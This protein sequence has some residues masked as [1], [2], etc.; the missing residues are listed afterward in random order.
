MLLSPPS[1]TLSTSDLAQFEKTSIILHGELVQVLDSAHVSRIMHTKYAHQIFEVLDKE[2]AAVT[3]QRRVGLITKFLNSSMVEGNSLREYLVQIERLL[4][5]IAGSGDRLDDELTAIV[6]LNSLPSSYEVFKSTVLVVIGSSKIQYSR[7]K[8][9]ALAEA[10]RRDQPSSSVSG[11]QSAFVV[12]ESKVCNYCKKLGH[13]KS[14]CY[15]LKRKVEFEN[16]K[17]TIVGESRS[18]HQPSYQSSYQSSHQ[19]SHRS[20]SPPSPSSRSPSPP[21]SSKPP[22]KAFQSSHKPLYIKSTSHWYLDSG[23]TANMTPNKSSFIQYTPI[24]PPLWI[25][26]ADGRQLQAV[27]KGTISIHLNSPNHIL[28]PYLHITNVFHVPG[29]AVNLLSITSLSFFGFSTSF[30]YNKAYI[31]NSYNQLV[32]TAHLSNYL[33]CLD[34]YPAYY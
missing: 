12:R 33:F 9:L 21:H 17:A 24:S 5:E 7:V 13:V 22:L 32:A 20:S 11:S 6:F 15:K 27:G 14:E 10:E 3:G 23:A 16:R 18:P 1:P 31:T 26:F 34:T 4:N 29:M 30:H 19:S 28:N 8:E 25:T 2:Y